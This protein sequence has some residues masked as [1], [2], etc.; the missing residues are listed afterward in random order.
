MQTRYRWSRAL[1]TGFAVSTALAVLSAAVAA[2]ADDVMRCNA[3]IV[4]VGMVA[5]EVVAKCGEPKSKEVSDVPI[6]VRLANGTMATPG[7][8]RVERWTYD[9]GYGQFPALLTF[10]D[11]KLKSIQLLTGGR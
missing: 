7:S 9:R 4:N 3:A 6:R 5:P 2:R 11:G 8:V 1:R 10:E